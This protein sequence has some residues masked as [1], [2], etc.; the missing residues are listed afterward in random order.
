MRSK[1]G[2][3]SS[4]ACHL[5]CFIDRVAFFSRSIESRYRGPALLPGCC[6][7][8]WEVCPLCMW[9]ST[10]AFESRREC[11]PNSDNWRLGPHVA[12]SVLSACG[13]QPTLPTS[14]SPRTDGRGT[15]LCD[16]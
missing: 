3:P 5:L 9:V 12:G 1:S 15:P 7:C 14:C 8:S 11:K 13:H 6:C 4:F 10:T 16:I 2:A